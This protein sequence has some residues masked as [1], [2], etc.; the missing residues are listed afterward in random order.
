[1][2][3]PAAVLALAWYVWLRV[4]RRDTLAGIGVYD[5]TVADDVLGRAA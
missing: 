1:M 2:L 4:R 5:E 3:G